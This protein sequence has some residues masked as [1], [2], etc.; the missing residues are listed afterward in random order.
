MMAELMLTWTGLQIIGAALWPP[1]KLLLE[2]FLAFYVLWTLFLAV[3]NLRRV[4]LAGQLSGK[5]KV[6]GAPL[7]VLGYLL[8]FVLNVGPMTLLLME[9]PRELTVSARLER[10]NLATSGWGKAVARWFEP[11]LDPFDPSG[12]H[13]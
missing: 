2:T 5:A 9:L 8:D 7:L 11:L 4:K 3:M 10:H 12:D 1:L 13:I 6:L